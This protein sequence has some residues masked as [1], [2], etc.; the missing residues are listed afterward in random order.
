[1]TIVFLLFISYGVCTNFA[2]IYI[3]IS[4]GWL[5]VNVTLIFLRIVAKSLS[6]IL[7]DM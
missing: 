3:P 4:A 5:S 2:K 1:M 6:N 7:C